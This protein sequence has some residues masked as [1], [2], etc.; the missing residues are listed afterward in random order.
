VS[1]WNTG[2][3]FTLGIRDGSVRCLRSLA[4]PDVFVWVLT[5]LVAGLRVR[6]SAAFT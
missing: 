5:D 3:A 1:E 2:F 4:A 6:L